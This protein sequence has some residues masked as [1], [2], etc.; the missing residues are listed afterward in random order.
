VKKDAKDAR[1]TATQKESR[2][3]VLEKDANASTQEDVKIKLL[4]EAN[5]LKEEAK[6]LRASVAW[7]DTMIIYDR[8]SLYDNPPTTTRWNLPEPKTLAN[9][10]SSRPNLWLDYTTER[11]PFETPKENGK[12]QTPPLLVGKNILEG[13]ELKNVE[14][15]CIAA[16]GAIGKID[17]NGALEIDEKAKASAVVTGEVRNENDL[18]FAF[19][20][21]FGSFRYY[22]GG[23]LCG[24]EKDTVFTD[25]ETPLAT[26]VQKRWKD[27]YPNDDFH[28]CAAKINHHGS[29]KTTNEM[30]KKV[31]NPRLAVISAGNKNFNKRGEEISILP[32]KETLVNL[33]GRVFPIPKVGGRE[34]PVFLTYGFGRSLDPMVEIYEDWLRQTTRYTAPPAV[35]IILLVKKEEDDNSPLEV[36]KPPRIHI[37]SRKRN[38]D[39]LKGQ[40][41]AKP[42]EIPEGQGPTKNI[43]YCNRME[44][45]KSLALPAFGPAAPS[46][47]PRPRPAR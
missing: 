6:K 28:V 26:W 38:R 35:D 25:M 43:Y 34:I 24:S 10:F 16:N 3:A 9:R 23:D 40:K 32:D 2:A 4:A 44:F 1:D 8:K 30:F 11:G 46:T 5:K 41:N 18:S 17:D 33:L 27:E 14:M 12:T 7:V 42:Y 29:N 20:L 22:T 47:S 21:R 37:F 31:F 36:G 39:T 15:V 19:L 45:H 13:Y